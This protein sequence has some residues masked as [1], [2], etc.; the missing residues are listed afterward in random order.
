MWVPHFAYPSRARHMGCVFLLAVGNNAAMNVDVQIS[1]QD[2][3]FN[4]FR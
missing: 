1:P 4:S 2:L 3:A